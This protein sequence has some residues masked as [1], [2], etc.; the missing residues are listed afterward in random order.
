MPRSPALAAAL[1]L[2][3]A[4]ALGDDGV[5][6]R[7]ALHLRYTATGNVPD[8]DVLYDRATRSFSLD[9]YLV[10]EGG[11]QYGSGFASLALDGR[12]LGG[13]LRWTVAVDTGELRRKRFPGIAPVC[14]S[15]GATGLDEPGS[16]QC[17]LYLLRRVIVP[18]EETGLGDPELTSNG[19]PIEEEA[20][21]TFL[22]REAYAA[23]SFGRAGF[24]TVRAGR[25][26]LTVGDGFVYD[27]YGTGLEVAA[28]LGAIGPQWELSAAIFQPSRDFPD[29]VGDISPMLSVR[30]DWLP[31]LFEHAGLFFALHRDRT[32]SLAEIFRGA[33]VER[34]ATELLRDPP[35]EARLD[36]Q[37]LALFQAAPAESDATL[38]WLGT[39]GS[40]APWRGHR[41]GWTLALLGGRIEHIRASLIP[42]SSQPPAT[43]AE[44]L[45]LAGRLASLRWELDVGR[46]L[47]A[48]ASFLFLSGDELP[49]RPAPPAGAARA[50]LTG[51]YRGFIG[52]APFV[53]ATNLFFGGGLSESFAAREATAPGVNGRGV[54]A[55]G[56]SLA[57]DATDSL[58]L[59]ASGTWLASDAD[60]PF[61]GR[62]YGT[63]LDLEATWQP[64]KWI[65]VGAELDALF[66]GDFFPGDRTITKAVL[67]VDLFTP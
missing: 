8:A 67:A 28:D 3:A 29:R 21:A 42:D 26:R 30:A 22:V 17:T 39:S 48:G 45:T 15:S 1:L 33:V 10:P 43:V 47:S 31:S 12:H 6:A 55:P 53:T 46:G 23:Y 19:R 2:A 50:P 35:A 14:L 38:G 65:Q 44:D 4:P 40:L 7:A 66:P 13:D 5:T 41:L 61:G 62:V 56:L 59:Q 16:G 24:A 58:A 34:L 32:G 36:A 27:D 63:E 54:I 11:E 64:A 52:I 18:L 37:S 49:Q 20:K 25:K 57:W 9:G 60:G 51:T